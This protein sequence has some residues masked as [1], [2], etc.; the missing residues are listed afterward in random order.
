MPSNSK[1]NSPCFTQVQSTNTFR[2]TVTHKIFKIY[3]K[4]NCKSKYLIDLPECVLAT[5][6]TQV[7]LKQPLIQDLT[8]IEKM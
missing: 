4:L 5:N 1:L 6:N 3:N 8:T 7:N 2:S